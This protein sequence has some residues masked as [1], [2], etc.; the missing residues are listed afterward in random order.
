[1]RLIEKKS[2]KST[3][4]QLSSIAT[5]GSSPTRGVGTPTP[6]TGAA[7][8]FPGTPAHTPD[9]RPQAADGAGRRRSEAEA[10]GSFSLQT[11]FL[12]VIPQFQ[13]QLRLSPSPFFPSPR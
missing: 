8:Y 12:L 2:Y 4:E 13:G 9:W 3:R 1:M 7:E 6:M 11:G 5:A 10:A